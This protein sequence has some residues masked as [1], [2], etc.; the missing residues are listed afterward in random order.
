MVLF[1]GKNGVL[2]PRTAERTSTSALLAATRS[3][4]S[5]WAWPAEF[6]A[7]D[8]TGRVH[9]TDGWQ[10]YQSDDARQRQYVADTDGRRHSYAVRPSNPRDI[11]MDG[12]SIAD[13][14]SVAA[15]FTTGWLCLVT[16]RSR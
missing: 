15:A 2:A 7:T 13:D 8:T 3:T 4:A 11:T 10:T 5:R 9:T 14:V 1:A 6:T 12:V 16:A